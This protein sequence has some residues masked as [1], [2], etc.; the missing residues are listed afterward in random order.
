MLFVGLRV[1][2]RFIPGRAFPHAPVQFLIVPA[3]LVKI[4]SNRCECR[5]RARTVACSTRQTAN[6]LRELEKLSK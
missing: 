4:R 1:V 3:H 2:R 6:W 5:C